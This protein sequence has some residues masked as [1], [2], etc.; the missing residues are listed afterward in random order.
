LAWLVISNIKFG[1]AWLGLAWLD[2]SNIKFGLVW[3][4]IS[5]IKFGLACYFKYKIRL[6]TG[7]SVKILRLPI[8]HVHIF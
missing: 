1:L 4:V 6:K 7:A 5:N 8:C 3:L 2:I